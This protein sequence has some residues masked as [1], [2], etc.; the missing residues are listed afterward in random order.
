M[1]NELSCI[2]GNNAVCK[3]TIDVEGTKVNQLYC[4]E[5]GIIM[6]SPDSDKDGKWLEKH[7]RNI[8]M[9]GK[10]RKCIND[11]R[12]VMLPCKPGDDLYWIDNDPDSTEWKVRCCKKGIEAVLVLENNEFAIMADGQIDKI[13]GQYS[14]LTKKDAQEALKVM[15]LERSK[16]NE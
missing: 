2:C 5:C 14:Y 8:H 7:W 11:D 15:L 10:R 3:A 6:R 4:A 1:N 16:K 12:M 9:E 13:G